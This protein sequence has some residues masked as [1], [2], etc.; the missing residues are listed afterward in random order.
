M[1]SKSHIFEDKR[2]VEQ[3]NQTAQT[4]TSVECFQK[5]QRTA[6][7]QK[8]NTTRIFLDKNIPKAYDGKRLLGVNLFYAV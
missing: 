5:N 8:S 2:G 1:K 4:G 3:A 7:C 6:D